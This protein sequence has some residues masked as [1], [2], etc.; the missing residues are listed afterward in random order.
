MTGMVMLT[1]GGGGG[2]GENAAEEEQ[3]QLSLVALLVAALRKSMVACRVDH[4]DDQN[5][6]LHQMEI[7]WPTNV[8]HLTHV[9]FDRFHG[10]LGLP[11]EFEV[12]IP[13]RVPS[14]S[15]S[16]FG[17]SAESM[18]CSYDS[19]GNS[20]PTILL[21]MQE[22][23]YAQGGLKAEGIFRINA[24]NSKEEEVREQLNRGTVP[25]DIEV[26]CLAGLIKAWFRELPCGV[27]D[28][29][30]PEEVLQCNTEDDCAELVKHLKP[31]ETALLNWAV[32]LMSDVVEHEESNKMNARNIAMVFAPNMT[33]M[34]DPLTALMHAVQVMNLLKTLITKTLRE[35]EE[36]DGG[37]SPMSYRSEEIETSC[38]L[39]R[40][41][42]SEEDD[43]EED[44]DE[45]ESLSEMEESF[46]K[47]LI[48][49]ENAKDCFKKELGNLVKQ[50]Q[51]CSPTSGFDFQEESS[52]N[53]SVS[54]SPG[55]NKIVECVKS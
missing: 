47:Q 40:Q 22:R 46:L 31:T 19:R 52:V 24:E 17:V 34:S 29:L 21:L 43:I 18:Q 42:S 53:T 9:T 44:E 45:V 41:A 50:Q 2:G 51:R 54:V 16:V 5:S 36:A 8:Q 7:G 25:E 32:D 55:V 3:N 11:V 26:H 30:S 48:E 15:V 38:E 4:R 1:R 33:Q 6:A 37:Y 10:F 49:N 20:V 13:C 12:E 28:G 23:L 27:L 14:A 35:R 39:T